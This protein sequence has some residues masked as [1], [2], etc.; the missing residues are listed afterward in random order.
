M[1]TPNLDFEH[2]LT[3]QQAAAEIGVS[4]KTVEAFAKEQRL[5]CVLDFKRATGGPRIAIYHPEDVA[6]IAAARRAGPLPPAVPPA[7]PVRPVG[8]VVPAADAGPSGPSGL[9]RMASTTADTI[10]QA[11]TAAFEKSQKHGGTSL[12]SDLALKLYLT[13]PEAARLS[14]LTEARI[15]RQ[16]QDG[17]LPALKDGGW[18]IRRADLLAL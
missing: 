17:T 8:R 7:P 3:K 2:W 1:T 13:I 14:G 15:R 4:T 12:M 11:L 18:K 5:R 16:C 10:V 9:S 6:D